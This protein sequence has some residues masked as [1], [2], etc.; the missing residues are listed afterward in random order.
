KREI[1]FRGEN[2]VATQILSSSK[3]AWLIIGSQVNMWLEDQL[4]DWSPIENWTSRLRTA[5]GHPEFTKNESNYADFTYVD[6]SQR[7]VRVLKN[8]GVPL[9]P[10]WSA[11]TTYHLEVKSTTAGSGR[12]AG[13]FFVS[14]NQVVRL[15]SC[16]P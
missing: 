3:I 4:P 1:G 7:M 11:R 8:A 2:H 13:P 15:V 16:N 5:A 10:H 14:D 6:R 9:S 12:N